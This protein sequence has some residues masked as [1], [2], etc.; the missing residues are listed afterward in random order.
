MLSNQTERCQK[1]EKFGNDMIPD[2]K[3]N[4]VGRRTCWDESCDRAGC[5]L[6]RALGNF[7]VFH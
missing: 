7:L 2:A 6:R 5:S 3:Y 1:V 4:V